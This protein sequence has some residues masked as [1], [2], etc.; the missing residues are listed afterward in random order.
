MSPLT[1]ELVRSLRLRTAALEERIARARGGAPQGQVA[2]RQALDMLAA[3]PPAVVNL[4][5]E[6]LGEHEQTSHLT[7]FVQQLLRHT[8]DITS[9]ADRWLFGSP[10]IH[11]E[12]SLL[13]TIEAEAQMLGLGDRHPIV[14][15]GDADNFR[16]LVADPYDVVFGP[17][18]RIG[19]TGDLHNP[20]LFAFLQVPEYEGRNGP[21]RPIILGHELAHLAVLEHDVIERLDLARRLELESIP[22]AAQDAPEAYI[23]YLE[24]AEGWATELLCDA[25]AVRRFGPAALAS[26]GE[27]LTAAGALSAISA[28]HPP[29]ALRLHVMIEWLGQ[30]PTSFDPI[31]TVWQEL[32]ST[33]P[34]PR[35]PGWL[36]ELIPKILGVVDDIYEMADWSAPYDSASRSGIVDQL[37]AH[38]LDGVPGAVRL[39]L[40]GDQEGVTDADVVNAGWL[41]RSADPDVPINALVAKNLD[42]L[43]LVAQWITNGGRLE[44]LDPPREDTEGPEIR[45]SILGR[46]DLVRRLSRADDLRLVV[47]PLLQG[48]IGSAGMDVRLGNRFIVFQRSAATRF[49][50]LST[51]DDPR[52][53][54][55]EVVQPWGDAFVLHPGELVLATTIE[56]L[57]LPRD[58]TGQVITRS[59]YGRLGLITAT[60]IQVNPG[61]RGCLTLELVNLGEVP[62]LLTPGERIAQL[63]FSPTTPEPTIIASKYDCPT[64]PQFSA[65]DRDPDAGILRAMSR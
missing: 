19:W 36:V 32:S 14:V 21:W 44:V 53:L 25:H 41:A 37:R 39:P 18:R 61:F 33:R 38:L 12:Q 9:F 15:P 26:L 29:A 27:F 48:A 3:F 59:S 54:Q 34:P 50:P 31:R 30:L 43:A 16:T 45:V 11:D 42:S 56:Y 1:A 46:R 49:D 40:Q 22:I 4:L 5:T 65:V 47:T 24:I 35:S 51:E 62:L 58:L 6:A 8:L 55:R 2:Y 23:R 52:S 20:Q 7:S 28:T 10:R 13:F 64:G 63:T 17:L 57:R 60:A